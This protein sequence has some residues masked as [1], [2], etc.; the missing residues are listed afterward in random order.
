MNRSSGSLPDPCPELL[1]PV[2]GHLTDWL[3]PVIS[4]AQRWP[5]CFR[6]YIPSWQRATPLRWRQR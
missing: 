5:I 3:G 2:A 4:P 6:R 1:K